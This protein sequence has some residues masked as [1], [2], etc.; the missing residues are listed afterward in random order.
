VISTI[1]GWLPLQ[2]PG[3]RCRSGHGRIN[4]TYLVVHLQLEGIAHAFPVR[5][6][7]AVDQVVSG[8]VNLVCFIEIC[9]SLIDQFKQVVVDG[10][11][12]V[13][14]RV[15]EFVVQGLAVRMSSRRRPSG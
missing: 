5:D 1:P 9:Q 12:L 4:Q 8:K 2:L 6:I 11:T 10:C 7:A 3:P 14:Y 15:G 13:K